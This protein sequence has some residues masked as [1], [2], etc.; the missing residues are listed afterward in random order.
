VAV[1]P[2]KSTPQFG[3]GGMDEQS[4]ASILILGVPRSGTSWLGKIFDSH[5]G[6]IYRHEPDSVL[7][8]SEFPLLCPPH[9]IPLYVDAVRNY[10]E[11]LTMVRQVKSSGTR[12]IFAKPFQPFPAP[13]IRRALA[14]G[15]RASEGVMPHAAWPKR[16]AI[17]DFIWGSARHLTYVIKSINLIESSALLAAALPR[18]RIIAIFRHPCGQIASTKR[19][20]AS[21]RMPDEFFGPRFLAT[22]RAREL[23]LTREW[24]QGLTLVERMVWGWTLLHA[25]LFDEIR[26]LPNVRLLRYEDLCRDPIGEARRLFA[27]AGLDWSPETERF[28]ELSTSGKGRGGYFSLFRDPIAAA[29]KWQHELSPDEIALC[30][31]ILA[32][33]LP[34]AFPDG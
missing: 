33:I 6:V 13:L 9:E 22:P 30:R 4:A 14:F 28:I 31:S 8:P 3:R 10:I 1:S 20:I 5:P 16:V 25:K 18:A 19:G 12:P 17:P 34:A 32:Q 2:S 11:R 15:L 7:P 21:G 24:Y 27:F 26:D 23:A 29:T